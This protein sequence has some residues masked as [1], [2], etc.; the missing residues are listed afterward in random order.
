MS[1]F[2]AE[3]YL[4][5]DRQRLAEHTRISVLD[6]GDPNA[7]APIG[8]E[9]TLRD[10]TQL[11]CEVN[12]V[13]GSPEN[14]MTHAAHLDKFRQ[15]CGDGQ[16]RIPTAQVDGMIEMVDGL[17]ALQNVDDLVTRSIA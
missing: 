5:E 4:R 8:I 11:R 2:T 6:A 10:G 15:N 14:P 9:I 16:S 12:D 1:D 3:A 7:L 13:Y 17:E